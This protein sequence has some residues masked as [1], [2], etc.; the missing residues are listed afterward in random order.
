MHDPEGDDIVSASGRIRIP[1]VPP[2]VAKKTIAS[3]SVADIRHE[4]GIIEC[5][6]VIANQ[7]IHHQ[8][9]TEI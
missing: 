8:E 5:L 6:Q 4:P 7:T 3:R 2:G 1:I 9:M